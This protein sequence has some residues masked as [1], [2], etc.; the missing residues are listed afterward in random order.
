MIS[1]FG[2]TK[3]YYTQEDRLAY[4]TNFSFLLLTDFLSKEGIKIH[5][6]IFYAC[7]GKLTCREEEDGGFNKVAVLI[8]WEMSRH[9]FGFE[10][11]SRIL[12]ILSQCKTCKL[13]YLI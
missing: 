4:M 11:K 3:H 13:L 8:T 2:K 7:K 9:R 10:A 12:F 1:V 5:H 6:P